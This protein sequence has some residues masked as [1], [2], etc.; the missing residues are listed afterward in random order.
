MINIQR[1]RGIPGEQ[2][3]PHFLMSQQ[4]LAMQ[5]FCFCLRILN[6]QDTICLVSLHIQL[7]NFKQQTQDDN[8]DTKRRK[9]TN[10]LSIPLSF[11]IFVFWDVPKC[12]SGVKNQGTNC[13]SFRKSPLMIKNNFGSGGRGALLKINTF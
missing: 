12:M 7:Q 3:A 11:F 13:N 2:A 9:I 10:T 8:A 4:Q 6:C 1:T 5:H